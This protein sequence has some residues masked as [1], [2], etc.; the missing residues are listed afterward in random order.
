MMEAE[1]NKDQQ[2]SLT[3]QEVAAYL[4]AHP[5]FL[6]NHPELLEEMLPPEREQGDNVSDF[7]QFAIQR[8]QGQVKK[9]RAHFN[10]LVTSAQDNNSVQQQVHQAVIR[11]VA[12][13]GLEQLLEVLT[14]DLVQLFGV[15]VVRLGMESPAAGMYESC[16]PEQH[17]SGIVFI[18]GSSVDIL[19]E[20]APVR[21]CPDA[22][23]LPAYESGEVFSECTRLVAS[24]ALLRL[25]LRRQ[26]RHALLAFGTREKGRY[27]PE[28]GAELLRFLA[29]IIEER[30]DVC[31]EETGIEPIA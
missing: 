20:G 12:A 24:C 28:Q 8:L 3:E 16:Y 25:N 26:E 19:T 23:A 21:L 13:R 11:L 10:R 1:D 6:L 30:L 9:V 5:D 7:Q 15:D 27:A 17:Y 22:A 14:T 18:P 31:L 29:R 2:S 4:L